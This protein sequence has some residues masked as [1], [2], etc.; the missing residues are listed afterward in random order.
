M[1]FC[2]SVLL[3]LISILR[4]KRKNENLGKK[5][6]KERENSEEEEQFQRH[7]TRFFVT[8]DASNSMRRTSDDDYAKVIKIK[9]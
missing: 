7:F 9:K 2:S 1:K 4:Q 3:I 5:N 8:I 6:T